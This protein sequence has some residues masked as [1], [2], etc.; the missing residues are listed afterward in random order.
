MSIAQ[1]TEYQVQLFRYTIDSTGWWKA[2]VL[3]LPQIM[4]EGSSRES[5]LEEIT[6]KLSEAVESSEIV[7]IPILSHE[8]SSESE[9]AELESRLR[10]Q[11]YRHYGI[12][13]DDPGAM[14]VF[15]EIEHHRNQ[16]TIGGCFSAR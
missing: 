2:C 9:D 5:V 1:V 16:Q 14:D 3:S 15:D 13:A 12:F 4:A 6:N 7:T 11:G 8:A 10:E